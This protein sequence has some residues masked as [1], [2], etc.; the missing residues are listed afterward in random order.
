MCVET[1][2]LQQIA[3]CND[4]ILA[5]SNINHPC[6]RLVNFQNNTNFQLSEPW[7]GLIEYC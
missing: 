2:L 4:V 1:T 6:Y 3:H 5:K 7:N